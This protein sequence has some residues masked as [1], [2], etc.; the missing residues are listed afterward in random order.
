MIDLHTHSTASDGTYSPGELIKEA[1]RIGLQAVAL[2]DHD[3]IDG[4]REAKLCANNIGIEFVPGIEISVK[5]SRGQDIKAETHILGFYIDASSETLISSLE[6]IRQARAERIDAICT[7]LKK[8]NMPVSPE[9][10]REYGGK[11]VTGRSHIARAMKA[12]GYVESVNEAFEK[13]LSSGCP[14]YA[15]HYAMSA[16]EAIEL[17]NSANGIACCAHLHLLRFENEDLFR[18][19]ER[20]KAAGLRGIEGYYPSYAE[21][22]GEQYR[23][24]ACKLGLKLSGG[25]DFHGA[26]RPEVSLGTGYGDMNIPYSLLKEL[27]DCYPHS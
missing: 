16:E 7:K 27:R 6:K 26:N 23:N 13:Y 9:S 24:L 22:Q 11:G 21:E 8:M 10:L 15:E 12:L 25:T 2:T 17:I 14:A 1:K 20:L 19:L 5:R 4:L 18:F 3:N